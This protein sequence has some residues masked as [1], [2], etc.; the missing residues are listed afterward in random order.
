MG[1]DRIAL[2]RTARAAALAALL[3]GC[4]VAGRPLPPGPAP[5]GVPIPHAISTPD[6]VRVTVSAPFDVR[7]R[8]I[9]GDVELW[10]FPAADC[11]GTPIAR[12]DAA[13]GVLIPPS[14]VGAPLRLVQVRAGRVGEPSGPLTA[15]WTAPPPALETPLAYV[16]ESDEV[17]L[18]WLPPG[19]P[20]QRVEIQRDGVPIDEVRAE[21]AMWSERPRRAGRYRYRIVGVGFDLRTGPSAAVEVE[22]TTDAPPPPCCRVDW[23]DMSIDGELKR[24]PAQ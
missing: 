23:S 3:G 9:E 13:T 14:H 21:H 19:A 4:G 20:L 16:D 1:P 22:V 6:G 5:P 15:T 11:E 8:L 17:H 7:G 24:S 10:L 12:G 2:G 18:S